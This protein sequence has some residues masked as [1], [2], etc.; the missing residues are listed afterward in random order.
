MTPSEWPVRY[1]FNVQNIYIYPKRERG[2]DGWNYGAKSMGRSL[3][4]ASLYALF[5]CYSQKRGRGL[6]FTLKDSKPARRCPQEGIFSPPTLT[7]Q[8]K[9]KRHE[10]VLYGSSVPPATAAG[11]R[12]KYALRVCIYKRHIV[13]LSVREAPWQLLACCAQNIAN[14]CRLLVTPTLTNSLCA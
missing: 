14:T 3:F 11:P 2:R 6:C 4:P 1:T 7:K 12:V 5:C 9:T 8:N 10:T 13:C